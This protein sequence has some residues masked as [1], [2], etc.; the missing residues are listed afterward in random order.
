MILSDRTGMLI[1]YQSESGRINFNLA[2]NAGAPATVVAVPPD[3]RSDIEAHLK[4]G[5]KAR[6]SAAT[7][8]SNWG[9]GTHA[10]PQ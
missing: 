4:V 5:T 9:D 1:E 3:V 8:L 2:C 10:T 6:L 7:V